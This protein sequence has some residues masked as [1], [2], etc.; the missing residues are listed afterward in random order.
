MRAA[1]A[2]DYLQE[3]DTF[4]VDWSSHLNASREEWVDT[5]FEAG[6]FEELGAALL[7]LPAGLNL[8]VR[9]S[10]FWTSVNG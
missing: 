3:P 1:V 6:R 8:I 7:Q 4:C 10:A 9:S 5:S 2:W